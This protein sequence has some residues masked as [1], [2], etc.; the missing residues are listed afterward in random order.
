MSK[1]Q[2]VRA[3]FKVITQAHKRLPPVGLAKHDDMLITLNFD[4]KCPCGKTFPVT[5]TVKIDCIGIGK[6]FRKRWLGK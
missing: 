3:F 6:R 2:P 1:K 5:R 4:C